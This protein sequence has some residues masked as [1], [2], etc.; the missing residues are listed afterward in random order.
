MS[1]AYAHGVAMN[2]NK[3]ILT[4]TKH[5]SRAGDRATQVRL[6]HMLVLSGFV[7]LALIANILSP[8]VDEYQKDRQTDAMRPAMQGLAAQG[9]DYAALWLLEHYEGQNKELIPG[10]ANKGY[11]QAMWWQSVE[12]FR[13]GRKEQALLIMRQAAALGY[14]KAMVSLPRLEE[15]MANEKHQ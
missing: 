4:I 1:N 14:D 5:S 6:K 13:A 3:V 11:P 7:V 10:L 12:E 9:K 15:T 2:W 8:V